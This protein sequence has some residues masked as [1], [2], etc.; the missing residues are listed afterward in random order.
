MTLHSLT[1]ACKATIRSAVAATLLCAVPLSATDATMPKIP[2]VRANGAAA[3]A[4]LLLEAPRR[5]AT[6]RRLVDANLEAAGRCDLITSVGH[7][8]Q[9]A[10]EALSDPAITTN[11]ALFL[12]RKR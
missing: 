1:P 2:R 5:S 10:A 12:S 11:R 4:V 3:I 6:F 8:L 7:E 9:H